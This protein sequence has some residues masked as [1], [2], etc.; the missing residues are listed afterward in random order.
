VFTTDLKSIPATDAGFRP[1][2]AAASRPA[3]EGAPLIVVVDDDP[4]VRDVLTQYLR[5]SGFRVEA[6]ARGV[7]AMRSLVRNRPALVISDLL[8]PE[9]D[10]LELLMSIRRL[11]PSPK[12]VLMTGGGFHVNASMRAAHQL[13]AVATLWKPF[14]FPALL[15][16]VYSA[17][18]A[19][20]AVS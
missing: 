7:D 16:V 17:L 15:D 20:A 19:P 6:F 5:R 11:A 2:G 8:M 9:T 13:G 10:G 4:M 1:V 12:V 14:E 18:T 3:A